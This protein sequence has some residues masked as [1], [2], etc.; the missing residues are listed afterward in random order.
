MEE[1]KG[2]L[3]ILDERLPLYGHRNWIVVADAAYPAQARDGIETVASGGDQVEVLQN[4]LDRIDRAT[5]VR[6]V[7]Y[8][9]RELD[10][11]AEPDAAGVTAYRECLAI[12]LKGH[13]TKRLPHEEIIALLDSAAQMFKVLIV[14]TT[15][16]IPYTSVFIQL[17]CG[18]WSAEAEERLRGALTSAQS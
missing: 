3:A 14:K 4:V 18:Y 17:D 13:T 15:L 5:H 12:L 11:V 16:T 6:P 1:F 2:G 7:I 9:D 10:F 8:V